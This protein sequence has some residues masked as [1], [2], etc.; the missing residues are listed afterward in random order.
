MYSTIFRSQTD[1]NNQ[2]VAFHIDQIN[3]Y[4]AKI[5]WMEA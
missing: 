2:V 4:I 1:D 3:I 5:C